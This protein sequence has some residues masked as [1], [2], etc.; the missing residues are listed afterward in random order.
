MRLSGRPEYSGDVRQSIEHV[1]RLE[2]AGLDIIWVAEAWGYD[3]ATLMGYL[4]ARTQRVQIGSGI[5]NIYSRTPALLAQTAAGLDV[6]SEG[7]AILGLGASGPQVIEGWHGVPYDRPL[8]RTREIVEICRRIW[9]REALSY[10]GECYTLPLPAEQGSGLGKPLKLLVRPPRARIPIY[11]A[12]LGARNVELTAEIADGWMPLFYV[13]EW[14]ALVWGES[15]ARG[16]AHRSADLGPLEIVAGG[17]VAIG[18]GL[19]HLRD[20]ARP[21]LALYLGGMGARG[22]NFYNDLICRYGFPDAAA[23]IQDLYLAGRRA[24]AAAAV[25]AELLEA[26][27]LIGSLGYVRDRLAAYHAAGVTILNIEPVGPDPLATIAQLKEWA[28][29][30]G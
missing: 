11:L 30:L 4:A 5:L 8:R 26:T 10:Q 17:P 23:E 29:A 7:R 18:E 12:A 6:L 20:L 25:P 21:R 19:E 22:H 27:T 1:V 3:A 14:A 16:R 24:E 13:P 15:R 9:R 2:Q 28:A